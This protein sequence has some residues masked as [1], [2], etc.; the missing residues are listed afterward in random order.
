MMS[1]DFLNSLHFNNYDILFIVRWEEAL[2][3]CSNLYTTPMNGLVQYLP[4]VSMVSTRLLVM[5]TWL[6]NVMITKM[7]I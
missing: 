1:I 4:E 6:N 5:S 3:L 2:G 7:Y